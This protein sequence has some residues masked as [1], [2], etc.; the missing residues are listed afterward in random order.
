M[1][2]ASVNSDNK[3]RGFILITDLIDIKRLERESNKLFIIGIFVSIIFHFALGS[4]FFS[5]KFPEKIV[6]TITVDLV[7]ISPPRVMRPRMTKPLTIRKRT[8]RKITPAKKPFDTHTPDIEF[9]YILPEIFDT[10]VVVDSLNITDEMYTY[11]PVNKLDRLWIPDNISFD[12]GIARYHEN[13]ISLKEEMITIKD[14]EASNYGQIK[15]LTIFNPE[16]KMSI[17]G[18]VYLPH[19][20]DQSVPPKNM[21]SGVLGLVDAVRSYTDIIAKADKHLNFWTNK[22]VR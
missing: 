5:F 8:F 6:K 11:F 17:T 4:Y 20:F 15:G 22:S 3:S 9:Q 14:I 18:I 7:V 10:P 1:L 16:N 21:S 13:T 2:Q 19:V 12:G